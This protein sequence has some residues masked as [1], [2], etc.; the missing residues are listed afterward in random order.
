MLP[1]S[2][3][4]WHLFFQR[5]SEEIESAK[6]SKK[7]IAVFVVDIVF[8][9]IYNIKFGFERGEEIVADTINRL[10]ENLNRVQAIERLS[11]H[12]IGIV[13]SDVAVP[14][15]LHLGAEKIIDSLANPLVI[16]DDE[17]PVDVA[18]GVALY[19]D[20][21]HKAENLLG[22]AFA[23][24]E[25]ARRQNTGY[26]IASTSGNHDGS[27]SWELENDL[28]Q[29]LEEDRLLLNYQPKVDLSTGNTFSFEALMR[30][31]HINDEYV[32]PASFIPLAETSYLIYDL[33]EWCINTAL[34][35]MAEPLQNN[36]DLSVAINLSANIIYDPSIITTV[37][38]ALE[39]WG[40]N[41]EQLILEVTESALMKNQELCFR[42]LQLLRDTGAKISIDDFGTGYSS[43]AYFKTIPAD[44][45]KID[46]S[47]I[48]S[49]ASNSDDSKI[50][51][52]I[53]NL[54][55]KFGLKVVAEGVEDVETLNLVSDMGCDAA[56]GYY[57][58]RPLDF[59]LFEEWLANK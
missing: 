28:K 4:N 40:V 23:S 7:R 35:E 49:M 2:D 30:W 42:N 21:G 6:D 47:F 58:S 36:G 19:P 34:R 55:H 16:G 5:L 17:I 15:L 52:S 9:H 25:S 38:S 48:R 29:A 56:Q 18:V 20:H 59:T 1:G 13:I 27:D 46:Q 57:I 3:T 14:E 32:S 51:D 10:D 11:P 54:S 12:Q 24:L 8:F 39:I 31:K 33:T 26:G 37:K 43:L 45:L 44:E 22:G 53:I 50:V 41:P